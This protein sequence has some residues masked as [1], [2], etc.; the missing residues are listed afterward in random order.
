MKTSMLRA[1]IVASVLSLI[2]GSSAVAHADGT[3]ARLTDAESTFRSSLHVLNKATALFSSTESHEFDFAPWEH[4][5]KRADTL[6]PWFS[7][8]AASVD[9]VSLAFSLFMSDKYDECA[10]QIDNFEWSAD[11]TDQFFDKHVCPFYKDAVVPCVNDFVFADLILPAM[12]SECCNDMKGVIAQAFGADLSSLVST[13]SK[14]V[15][16]A[17]CS[18][19]TTTSVH[20]GGV[21][22]TCGDALVS[23]FVNATTGEVRYDAIFD[24]VQIPT[25]QVCAAVTGKAF[26]LTSGDVA[27]FAAGA[28]G[29]NFGICFDPMDDLI[30]YVSAWPVLQTLSVPGADDSVI[31][32]TDLWNANKC[33]P[34]YDLIAGVLAPNGSFADMIAVAD[35]ITTVFS[36]GGAMTSDD[37]SEGS[38]TDDWDGS[39]DVDAS[40]ASW[41]TTPTK[42]SL[43]SRM[44]Q[45][46]QSWTIEIVNDDDGSDGPAHDDDDDSDGDDDSLASWE[47]ETNA[48]EPTFP[49]DANATVPVVAELDFNL[50]LHSPHGVTCDYGSERIA[51]AY[52]DVV[53]AASARAPAT[54]AATTKKKALA[55]LRKAA[56]AKTKHH[57][58]RQ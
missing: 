12:K 28:D 20:G 27:Q 37:G 15:G 33:V 8:C 26:T 53:P 42:R 44:L 40:I 30:D 19:K 32:L 48:P 7:Q 50:C 17:L 47:P 5:L 52:T 4:V 22:Q 13:L 38:D 24:A 14:L 43:A 46:V 35:A 9:V 16:N 41:P 25:D 23:T 55:A 54:A 57:R 58:F 56:A 18:T 11:S 21:T 34:A 29:A 10:A 3:C 49:F 6:A 36:I 31:P 2:L 51:L 39:R 1:G 45:T